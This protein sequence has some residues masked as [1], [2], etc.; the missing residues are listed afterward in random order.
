MIANRIA[1]VTPI[2]ASGFPGARDLLW[3]RSCPPEATDVLDRFIGR[4]LR[5]FG[6]PKDAESAIAVLRTYLRHARSGMTLTK[7]GRIAPASVASLMTELDPDQRWIGKA[8]RE[9]CTPVM[10]VLQ[11]ARRSLGPTRHY[12]GQVLLTRAAIA[13]YDKPDERWAGVASRLPVASSDAGLDIG[14]ILL[15]LASAGDVARDDRRLGEAV[16]EA[17]GWAGWSVAETPWRYPMLNVVK[18]TVSILEWAGS[19]RMLG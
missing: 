14:I 19:S 16:T 6:P 12:N 4:A 15:G 11:R 13:R 5:E 18:V 7:A 17:A 8:N 3:R 9:D 2:P 1:V 10:G